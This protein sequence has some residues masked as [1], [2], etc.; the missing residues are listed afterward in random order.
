MVYTVK[1][2]EE[3][4]DFG[5]E[6]RSADQG[7][8]AVVHLIA[9]DGTESILKMEDALLYQREINEGDR[10]CFDSH[11]QLEKVNEDQIKE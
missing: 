2:I 11:Q 3:D 1:A 8:K 4:L 5:C 7:V 6:E 9:E 10:V